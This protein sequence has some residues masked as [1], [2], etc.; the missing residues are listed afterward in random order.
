MKKT[1]ENIRETLTWKNAMIA[2]LIFLVGGFLPG[3]LGDIIP[4]DP[5]IGASSRNIGGEPIP[6]DLSLN[7]SIRAY[8]AW[9][10]QEQAFG[11]QWR[12]SIAEGEE[13]LQIWTLTLEDF[14]KPENLI[15]FGLNPASGGVSLGLFALGLFTRRP[16]DAKK[17]KEA[18]SEA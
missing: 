11:E 6:S 5:P 13:K 2:S 3:C 8:N 18:K 14:T 15:A 4:A 17:I 12:A 1:I 9:F 10:S 7:N 16:G